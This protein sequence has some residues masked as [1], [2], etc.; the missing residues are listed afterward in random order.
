[1]ELVHPGFR[2]QTQGEAT[3]VKSDN[4]N[5]QRNSSI[6]EPPGQPRDGV[7]NGGRDCV[8]REKRGKRGHADAANDL[9]RQEISSLIRSSKHYFFCRTQGDTLAITGKEGR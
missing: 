5:L 2:R 1:M 9:I 3:S 8:Q 4:L 7:G 6:D